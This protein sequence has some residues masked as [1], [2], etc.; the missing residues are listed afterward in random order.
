MK[1]TKRILAILL[2]VIAV[3]V[4]FCGC[5]PPQ[6][7]NKENGKL[8]VVTTIFPPYDFAKQVG[9]DKV[10]VSMLLK[11]GMESHNFDPTPQD[12][13]KVQ[14][15]DLFIYT[16]G[17][18]DKWVR[19]ILESDDKKPKKVL[20]MM[21]CVDKVAED[22]V[23]G[24]TVEEEEKD[25]D[26]IE[27]DEHVWTSPENAMAISRKINE[28]LKEL[29]PSDSSVFD[30]NTKKYTQELSALDNEFKKVVDNSKRKIMIFADRF[31]FRYFADAYGLSYFAAFPGCSADTEPSAATIS[32]LINKVND[33][34]IPVVFTIEFSN[35][36]IA[37]TICE[38]TGAKQLEFHSCHNVSQEML[39]NGSTYISIMKT[40]LDHL[41][42]A[43]A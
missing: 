25:S 32:F 14:D 36:K 7:D 17:E 43:L 1:I 15:A 39:D 4:L 37:D 27:Y 38:A 31:P 13:I 22:T 40:N 8:N 19:D 3:T 16:G 11:P 34:K 41:K 2:S 29:S 23:E 21:D 5:K 6:E 33:D 26:E 42:E 30:E 9:G 28:A 10:N 12:I 24:M 35:G 20:A 18:S